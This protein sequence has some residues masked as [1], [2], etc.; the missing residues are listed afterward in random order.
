MDYGIDWD[1]PLVEEERDAV[2]VTLPECDSPLTEEEYGAQQDE[3][4]PLA[5]SQNYGIDLFIAAV[6]FVQ[7]IISFHYH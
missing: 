3:V 4:L 7:D 2:Q 5:D 1:G 6:S